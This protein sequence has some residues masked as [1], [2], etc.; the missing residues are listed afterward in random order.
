MT[1]YFNSVTVDP[2]RPFVVIDLHRNFPSDPLQIYRTDTSGTRTVRLPTG[3]DEHRAELVLIDYEAALGPVTYLT[4]SADSADVDLSEHH[5]LP[6][7]SLPFTPTI[8]M[9]VPSVIVFD[10]PRSAPSA[11]HQVIGRRYP[12]ATIRPLSGRTG[13]LEALVRTWQDVK[14]LEALIELGQAVHYREANNP[15]MD[16][17]MVINSTSPRRTGG[18]WTVEVSWTEIAPVQAGYNAE[19]WTFDDLREAHPTFTMLSTAYSSFND[20]TA[21]G[22]L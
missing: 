17:Y 2:D 20:L 8:S 11:I 15:G 16:A 7:F 14:D 18:L 19:T 21:G 5:R 4:Y 13:R 9:T 10:G 12:L 22:R 3:F 6:T 1:D